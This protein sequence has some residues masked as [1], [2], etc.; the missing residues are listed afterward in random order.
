MPTEG[1]H[2][3]FQ[4]ISVEWV[5]GVRV[6]RV[7]VVLVDFAL[8]GGHVRRAVELLARFA[9]SEALAKKEGEQA[10]MKGELD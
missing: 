8:A 4:V 5:T 6:R 9:L 10:K 3:R 7:A 2:G 1:G